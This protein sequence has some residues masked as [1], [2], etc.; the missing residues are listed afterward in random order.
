M[1]AR[2]NEKIWAI[3]CHLS[4]FLG[5]GLLLPLIVYLAM[6]HESEYLA[7]NA[8]ES[9]NFHLSIMIYLLI[10]I[11]LMFVGVGILLAM[12]IG[13]FALVVSIVAAVQSSDGRCYRYPLCLRMVR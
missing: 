6:R 8:R 11:P 12:A 2:G 3:L 7:E 5:V 13:L 1:P 9:L 4:G 10:C